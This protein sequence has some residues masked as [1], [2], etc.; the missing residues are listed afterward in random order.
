MGQVSGISY[1]TIKY[2]TVGRPILP[3]QHCCTGNIILGFGKQKLHLSSHK[4]R[5]TNPKDTMVM[6]LTFSDSGQSKHGGVQ[7]SHGSPG[8]DD[9]MTCTC[10]HT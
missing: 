7:S 10:E 1:C 8:S 6:I 4:V 3:V 9:I 2:S 5:G